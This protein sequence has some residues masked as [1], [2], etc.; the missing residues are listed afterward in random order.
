MTSHGSASRSVT[1]GTRVTTRPEGRLARDPADD[2]A[3]RRGA[4]Q[5][6]RLEEAGPAGGALGA[7]EDEDLAGEADLV[8]LVPALDDHA[9]GRVDAAPAGDG[10]VRH[11]GLAL[12]D[13]GDDRPPVQD[14]P[15]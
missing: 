5:P 12:D 8:Q 15:L 10:L 9:A 4:R 11:Q 2:Q 14:A 7:R 3:D 13:A 1:A 6:R